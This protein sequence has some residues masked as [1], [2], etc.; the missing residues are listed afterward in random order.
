M[1]LNAQARSKAQEG[2]REITALRSTNRAWIAIQHDAA[3]HPV[4]FDRLC[5]GCEQGLCREISARLDAARGHDGAK[6]EAR[7]AVPE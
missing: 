5:E 4:A 6:A 2:R 1:H 7:G 3:G